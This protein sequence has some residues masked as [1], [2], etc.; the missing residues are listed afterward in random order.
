MKLSLYSVH[1]RLMNVHLAPFVARANVEALRQMKAAFDDP[2]MAKS[3][4]VTNPS[5]YDLVLVGSFDD[6]TGIL[7]SVKPEILMNLADLKN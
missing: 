5:D 3:P 6:E 2:N 7:Q 4:L 1:D